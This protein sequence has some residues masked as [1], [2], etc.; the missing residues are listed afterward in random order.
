MDAMQ[1]VLPSAQVLGAYEA[2]LL[3]LLLIEKR[4]CARRRPRHGDSR[5]PDQPADQTAMPE[6]LFELPV[7]V[8][9]FAI[10]MVVPHP[11]PPRSLSSLNAETVVVAVRRGDGGLGDEVLDFAGRLDQLSHFEVLGVLET[12]SA[13]EVNAAFLRAAGKF[14]PDRMLAQGLPALVHQAER[15]VARLGEASATL[16]DPERRAAY[17]AARSGHADPSMRAVIDA[18][19]TFHTGETCLKRGDHGGAVAAFSEAVRQNPL[20]PEY[21][22]YLAWAL[23]CSPQASKQTLARDTL[24]TLE[25]VIRERPRF[26]LGH[27][28]CGQI[29]N[30]LADGGK[31]TKS[32]RKALE[33][34]GTMMEAERELR[35]I[36]MR[37]RRSS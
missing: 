9:D 15:I 30:F 22:A 7:V 21:G 27:L 26:A 35:L 33:V 13:K 28:W 29:W 14:H 16:T 8:A 3:S 17:V 2:V 20:E 37:R 4:H 6:V 34:D 24:A 1:L 31:A 19:M 25:K 18:E 12:A 23:F 5:T 10:E 36:E 11:A 32:F